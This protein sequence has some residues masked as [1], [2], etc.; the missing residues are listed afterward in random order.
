MDLKEIKH[1]AYKRD[2]E[3]GIL[4][5]P[6]V[7]FLR[8]LATPFVRLL[9]YTP[10]SANMVSW[11]SVFM[12]FIAA[13]TFSIGNYYLMFLGVFFLFLGDFFDAA[14][15][16]LARCKKT[17]S[18]LQA[19]Y[20]CK[21]YHPGSLFIIFLGFGIGVWNMTGKIDFFYLGIACSLF[22]LFT[23]YIL[24]LKNTSLFTNKSKEVTD[25]SSV[26]SLF[27][28]KKIFFNKLFVFPINQI[29][30]ILL[31][32][33]VFDIFF[34]FFYFYTIY[35]AFRFLLFNFLILKTFKSLEKEI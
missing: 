3:L 4:K 8:K 33:I 23:V 26:R 34:F 18:N 32:V 10:I 7:R 2:V 25:I 15:G 1:Q 28:R 6:Y 5:V 31:I 21:I 20:I 24:E 12:V 14:D 13:Y 11:W 22:Q 9:L 35:L 30:L 19:D 29:I 17:V 16:L 27:D